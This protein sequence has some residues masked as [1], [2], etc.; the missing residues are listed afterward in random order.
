MWTYIGYYI[1]KP[2]PFLNQTLTRP[3]IGMLIVLV[4]LSD[5]S[6]WRLEVWEYGHDKISLSLS[7]W[8]M[9]LGMYVS[10]QPKYYGKEIVSN[11]HSKLQ[12]KLSYTIEVN[13][14]GQKHIIIKIGSIK[15]RI[16]YI[17]LPNKYFLFAC[18]YQKNTKCLPRGAPL[19]KLIFHVCIALNEF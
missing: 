6:Q 16:P 18:V 19:S 10:V 9:H 17:I 8:L 5:S 7:T 14:L 2:Y 13:Q 15:L 4:K 1:D 12:I 11:N 3:I